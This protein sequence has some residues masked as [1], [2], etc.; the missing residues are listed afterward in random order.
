MS[1]RNGG[2]FDHLFFELSEPYTG[3]R[4]E[5]DIPGS[6]YSLKYKQITA[7]GTEVSGLYRTREEEYFMFLGG[8]LPDVFSS[9]DAE[10]ELQVGP[11]DKE[12][13]T[14]TITK[15]S[16]VRIPRNWMRGN[17]RFTKVNK[18]LVYETALLAGTYETFSNPSP[19]PA[20]LIT[21]EGDVLT[22]QDLVCEL[23]LETTEWGPWCPTPQAYFR[24][25]TYMKEAGLHVGYQVF[26]GDFPMED[27]HMHQGEEYI[28]FLG[29]E[30][31]KDGLI[32]VFDFRGVIEFYI[33]SHPDKMELHLLDKPTIVRLP[34]NIWHSPINFTK[35]GGKIQFMATW[36]NGTWGT[37]TRR[38]NADG[39]KYFNYMGDDMRMCVL[40]PEKR[41]TL[42]T[43]CFKMFA[44]GTF[45]PGDNLSAKAD[46]I[47]Q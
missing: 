14:L 3:F 23:P 43:K 21:A 17:V 1:A 27:G 42:C 30:T 18:P 44:E 9:W 8:A 38:E 6:T 41:C 20:P 26:T 24:G 29:G 34:A 4:G 10:A 36:L 15:P 12:L 45:R 2:K 5:A 47:K 32:D 11:N 28:F 39:S 33:G 19:Y 40:N 46:D 25:T 31:G 35:V 16:V 22:V 37:I 7:P 13:T